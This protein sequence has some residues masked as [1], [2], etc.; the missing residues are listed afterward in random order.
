MDESRPEPTEHGMRLLII[1]GLSG[2]GKSVALRAFEDF[3][4]Y[5]I[6]NMPITLLPDYVRQA[7]ASD[8]ELYK[9]TAISVDARTSAAETLPARLAELDALDVEYEILYLFSDVDSLL[10]R[11]AETMEG[12]SQCRRS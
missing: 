5:C 11:Y 8:N 6:D 3:G 2:A 1:S 7:S 12:K 10:R 9:L 4:Y